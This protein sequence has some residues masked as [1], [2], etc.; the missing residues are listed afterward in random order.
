MP[1]IVVL[2]LIPPKMPKEEW[3]FAALKIEKGAAPRYFIFSLDQGYDGA[4]DLEKY[5]LLMDDFL[6]DSFVFVFETGTVTLFDQLFRNKVSSKQFIEVRELLILCCPSLSQYGLQDLSA[7]IN[8]GKR[9]LP[10]SPAHQEVRLI[11]EV[12]KFCWTKALNL[13][14]GY[15][16]NLEEYAKGL[17]S[18]PLIGFLK[19]EIVKQYPD[20][21]IRTGLD[22]K[23]E[24]GTLFAERPENE[25]D[26]VPISGEWVGNCFRQGGLLSKS[27]SGYEDR[28][29]QATMAE[30]IIKGFVESRDVLIEAGTGTGKS[31]AYL[32]P[33]IWWAK[34]EK[35]RVIVASHTIT[36]QEQLF[37]KD[38]PLLHKIL[39][40]Q[41]K[42]ALLKGKNNYLCLKSFYQDRPN[43]EC[44]LKERLVKAG[45]LSWIRETSTGDF[46]EIPFLQNVNLIWKKYGAD[47]PY[48]Q[49]AE[50][51]FARRCYLLKIR[52]KAEDADLIVINH[53]LLLADI[54][55][56]HKI[57]P[58]YSDLIVDEAH[59]IY[60]TALKQLGFEISLEQAIR[61]IDN[62]TGGKG[63]LV[64]IL[65]RNRPFWAEVY[66]TVNWTE[67]YNHLEKVSPFCTEITE[68]FKEL[69]RM[70]QEVVGGRL[71]IRIDES[72]LGTTVFSA[73]MIML[74][75]LVNRLTELTDVLSRLH[76]SLALEG[77]QMESVRYEILKNKNDL[78]QIIDGLKAIASKEEGNRVT[79][80]EK[81]NV[82]YLKN[83]YIDI[84][85]I[86]QERVFSK[87][88]ST[89]LTSATLTVADKF[90]YFARDIGV[91]EYLSLKLDS[92]FDYERQMLFCIVK[93]L[94]VKQWS[95]EILA[96]K[97]ASF[98]KRI[99]EV[100]GGRTLVLFT[101]HRYLRLVHAQL[102]HDVLDSGL[103]VLAQGI[104]GTR[105]VLL[106]DFMKNKHSLLLGTS[107][108]WEGIDIPGDS[109]R[110]V[111][112]TKLPFWPPDSPILEAK[113]QLLESQGY[114]PFQD[115]HL[116]EAIIR[117]KQGFG[118]LIRTKEDKGVVIL[119][120][121]RIL[122][123]YYGKSFL[124]SLPI[125]SYYQGSPENVLK[126]VGHW[127]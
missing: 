121:D 6:S 101:S 46:S 61:L 117:F 20:R 50:C 66:P 15:L 71:N 91:K 113:A 9:F 122:K 18:E 70:C 67:F 96:V 105:E 83:T 77:E 80:L 65:K 62:I 107:S 41:F 29:A 99:A 110:C 40:F 57:L 90:D 52:K 45:I 37:F 114:D 17:N 23:E 97:A 112:M 78:A 54:K 94:Q 126:Q 55:T 3:D 106:Q 8:F 44:S 82:I 88:N 74:E 26:A 93:D 79:Y 14:V 2:S 1:S 58:E 33:A 75:N 35:K 51:Q 95:E 109:L 64:P 13:D 47:N 28:T 36:L 89:V 34:K 124:K 84:V 111:I 103:N 10:R 24:S 108:F 59:N 63:G 31:L 56:N 53:S 116:P 42:K 27:F 120:D 125:L 32:I 22:T 11:W 5:N 119:L 76:S 21:P 85:G 49:P 127:V 115:L 7:K 60:Q 68:Q 16:S 81:S 100:M 104:D 25:P 72:K 48:C 19:K 87:N 30:A 12:L 39:P 38:L 102:Q 98:I 118:R 43:E 86:L 69:F 4:N 73:F 123:K 92:P